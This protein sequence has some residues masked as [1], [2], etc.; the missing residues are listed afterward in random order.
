MASI[1][2]PLVHPMSPDA[3]LDRAPQRVEHGTVDMLDHCEPCHDF[4]HGDFYLP[5]F[6]RFFPTD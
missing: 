2:S 6:R 1:G 5:T 4:E 3:R